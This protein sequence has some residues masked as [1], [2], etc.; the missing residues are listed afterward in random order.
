MALGRKRRIATEEDTEIEMVPIMNMFLVLIPFLLLSAS[1]FHIKAINTSVP[2]LSTGTAEDS[3]DASKPEIKI[4][5]ILE[6]RKNRMILTAMSDEIGYYDLVKLGT[7]IKATSDYVYPMD[8]MTSHLRAV[9]DKYPKSDTM[10][11]VPRGE[12]DYGTIIQA[13]D[14]A[15]A[16]NSNELFPNVVLSGKVG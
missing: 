15:R 10:I 7:T 9:K 16:F 6:L 12:T 14:A 11:L 1:F 8:Q 13:M 2:V 5:V 3:K 4:T